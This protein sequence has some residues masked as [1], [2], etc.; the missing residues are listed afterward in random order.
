MIL[1]PAAA[2]RNTRTAA[3]EWRESGARIQEPG[4]RIQEPEVQELQNLI[5]SSGREQFALE[6]AEDSARASLALLSG[7]FFRRSQSELLAPDS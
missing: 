4:F 6:A 3:E 5:V 1:A 7:F 2:E